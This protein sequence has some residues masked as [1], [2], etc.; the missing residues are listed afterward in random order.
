MQSHLKKGLASY[1]DITLNRRTTFFL[2]MIIMAVVVIDSTVVEISSYTGIEAPSSLNVTLFI[3]LFLVFVVVSTFLLKSVKTVLEGYSYSL[4]THGLRYSSTI[5]ITAQ[6][7]TITLIILI[8]LQIIFDNQYSI[9]IMR[10][11]TYVSHVSAA[12]VIAFLVFMFG[13]WLTSQRNITILL[14]TVS[15]LLIGMNLIVSL[16]YLEVYFSNSPV[17]DVSSYSIVSY[18]TNFVKSSYTTDLL[19][20]TFDILSISSF[21]L[22]WLATANLMKQYRRKMG[23]GKYF[24]LMALPL[25]YYVYPFQSYF[26]DPFLPLLQSFPVSYSI[27]YVLIFSITKQVGALFFSLAFLITSSLIRDERI[28]KSLLISAIG[29]AILVGSIEIAPLQY[30][31]YPPFGLVTEAFLPLGAYLLFIGI[32][33]SAKSMSRDAE[34]RREIY[35]R[36]ESQLDL[37]RAIGISEMEKEIIKQVKFLE[38]KIPPPEP[39]PEVL[40]D[41]KVKVIIRDVLEELY[42]IKQE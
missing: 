23:K 42:H 17:S 9:S 10:M 12:I 22:L 27:T 3:I 13:R 29:M 21:L 14:Y 7:L 20:R 19:S 16:M 5:P 11:Q 41:E 6:I 40:S 1:F 32:Y 18:V 30:H 38:S 2:I 24:L 37:L 15:F 34:I 26:G 39:E 36:A 35:K 28:K 31:V 33:F 8:T 25:I 4:I